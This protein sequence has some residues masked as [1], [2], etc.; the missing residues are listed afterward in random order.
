MQIGRQFKVV[1]C[2][3]ERVMQIIMVHQQDNAFKME[4][5]VIGV[6]MLQ[7]LALV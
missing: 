4:Q 6:Q 3:M 2:Q 7:I 1:K 5:L